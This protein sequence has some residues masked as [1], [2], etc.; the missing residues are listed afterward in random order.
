[1]A[2][3]IKKQDKSI[4]VN[5]KISLE[6]IANLIGETCA[7][8]Y[9]VIGLTQSRSLK[10]KVIILT[11]KN[12]VEGVNVTRELGK[13]NVDIHIVVASGVKITE[14]ASELSKRITYVLKKKYGELFKKVNV[15]VEEIREI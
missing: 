3:D 12:Y 9:G 2:Q 8:S 15:Y 7:E 10:E 13:F 4:S 5:V 1:M 11:K 6:E 14:I